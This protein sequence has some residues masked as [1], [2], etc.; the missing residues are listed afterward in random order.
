LL[1]SLVLPPYISSFHFLWNHIIL[2]IYFLFF[3]YFFFS[4]FLSLLLLRLNPIFLSS[5]LVT[6]NSTIKVHK[7]DDW[8]SN[9][10][11]LS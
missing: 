10:D 7:W 3:I 5:S 11:Q 1:L 2:Y 9:P 8:N 6:R 4:F